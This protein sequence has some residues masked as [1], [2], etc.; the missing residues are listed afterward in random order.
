MIASGMSHRQG[1]RSF[2]YGS[3]RGPADERGGLIQQAN[4]DQLEQ[5]N[6]RMVND[7]HGKVGTLKSL[8]INIGAEVRRQN[9]YLDDMDKEVGGVSGLLGGTM[10][11]LGNLTKM[12][13]HRH[14]CYLVLFV[15]FVF[16][17]FYYL[18]RR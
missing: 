15:V 2:L 12:G 4:E 1:N 6:D 18:L 3:G 16:F 10:K 5:N 8:V 14:T 11:R 13:G 7:L 9:D 17:I